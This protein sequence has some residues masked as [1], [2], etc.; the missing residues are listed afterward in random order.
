LLL[1]FYGARQQFGWAEA[2]RH[3]AVYI[4]V[5]S[6]GQGQLDPRTI[7]LHLSVCAFALYGTV[8]ILE[9]GRRR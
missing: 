6:F 3:L 9:T 4:Q 8:K 1:Y 5:R 7:A 2:I